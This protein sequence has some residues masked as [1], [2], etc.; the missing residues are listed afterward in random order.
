[1]LFKREHHTQVQQPELSHL[2]RLTIAV[3][4]IGVI[5]TCLGMGEAVYRL[6]FFDFDGATDRLPIEMCFGLVFAWVITKLVR[7][8]HQDRVKTSAVIESIWERN[9]KIGRAVQAIV[10]VPF[11]SHQQAIRVIRDQVERVQWEL[12]TLV[13]S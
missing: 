6:V 5:F 8:I 7:R 4:A 13:S 2:N 11:P 12:D 1:M 10:P 3:F 9:Q